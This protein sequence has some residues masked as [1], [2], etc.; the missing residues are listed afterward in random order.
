MGEGDQTPP[1]IQ[2]DESSPYP[3]LPEAIDLTKTRSKN[4]YVT[5]FLTALIMLMLV[6]NCSSQS[7][8]PT[9]EI[10]PAIE[11]TYSAFFAGQTASGYLNLVVDMTIENK[12]AEPFS[13]SPTKFSVIVGDYSYVPVQS[14]L[15]TVDLTDGDRVSGKLTFQVPPEAASTRVGYQMSYSGQSQQNVEWFKTSN[16]SISETDTAGFVPVM[17]IAY[18]ENFMWVEESS[19]LY[20]LVDM[21]IENR[22]Y[23]SFNTSPKY[24]SL[25]MG[26]IFGEASPHHPIPFDGLLSDQRDGS[27]SNMRSF[28][29]QNG[30]KISGR[31]AFKVPTSI[32]KTTESS[33][34]AYS[35]VRTYNIQ[36]TKLPPK[37]MK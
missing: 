10:S 21:T 30:A 2:I 16:P 12:G 37:P 5:S 3:C 13:T 32:F 36:W 17:E 9:P 24:F 20:L 23:E 6:T 14:Q 28:D 4:K 34:I 15:D 8:E 7:S 22:G 26:D 27:Y 35:G 18:S 33:K 11:I 1:L 29:L 31:L 19:S 25:V